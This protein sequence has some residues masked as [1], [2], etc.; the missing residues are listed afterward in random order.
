MRNYSMS[1]LINEDET[2]KNT[3]KTI[4]EKIAS[5]AKN[6]FKSEFF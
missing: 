5:K 2:E 3:L 4:V 6:T 1:V